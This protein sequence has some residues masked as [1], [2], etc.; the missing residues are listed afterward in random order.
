LFKIDRY[1]VDG[2]S[3][4]PH[5]RAAIESIALLASRLGAR[6]VAEG[7]ETPEDFATVTA[8]GI[9]LVQ[10]YYFGRPAAPAMQTPQ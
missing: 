3:E 10:G 2:C 7:I 1:F 9:D 4:K 8:L 5:S 6:V